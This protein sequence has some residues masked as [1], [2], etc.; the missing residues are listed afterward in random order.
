MEI[1]HNPEMKPMINFKHPEK[2][3]D[4]VKRWKSMEQT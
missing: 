2:I 1:M 3:L 4:D